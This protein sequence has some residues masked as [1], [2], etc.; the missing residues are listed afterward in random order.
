[1]RSPETADRE[2]EPE[3]PGLRREVRAVRRP[4]T[5]EYKRESVHQGTSRG[6]KAAESR[7]LQEEPVIH[8]PG[9]S[10]EKRAILHRGKP[11]LTRRLGILIGE[12]HRD[13]AAEAVLPEQWMRKL[14]HG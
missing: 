6:I 8:S 4:E 10:R 9:M 2:K 12:R 14:P 11:G 3:S 1:M 5:A 13:T 7:E